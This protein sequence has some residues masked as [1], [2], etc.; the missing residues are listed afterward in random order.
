[1]RES[2]IVYEK[3]NFW[4]HKDKTA[5]VVY[6]NTITHAESDSAYLLDDD[7]LSIAKARVDY[8]HKT[9]K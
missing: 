9:R 7:G 3:G 5:Y 1:M 4:V 2:D 8:L 6:R